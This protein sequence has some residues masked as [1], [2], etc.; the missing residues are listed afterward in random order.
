[1]FK[2]VKKP[3]YYIILYVNIYSPTSKIQK[4]IFFF[5]NQARTEMELAPTID[6]PLF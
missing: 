5:K 4:K 2:Q 6:P 3:E 1:M